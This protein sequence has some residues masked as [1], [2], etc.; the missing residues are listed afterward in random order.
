MSSKGLIYLYD[1][2]TNEPISVKKYHDR[3]KRRIIINDWRKKY[4]K[5]FYRCY[6]IISPEIPDNYDYDAIE[7]KLDEQVS[8]AKPTTFKRPKAEYKGIYNTESKYDYGIIDI[9]K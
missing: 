6:I 2:E 8:N 4:A 5:A 1:S 3:P 9:E 7:S